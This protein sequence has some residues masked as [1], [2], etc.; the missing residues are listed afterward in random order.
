MQEIIDVLAVKDTVLMPGQLT[1][2]DL[3][4]EQSVAAVTHAL[5]Q[6]QPV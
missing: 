3:G 5:K 2:F 6:E 4:K 1:S